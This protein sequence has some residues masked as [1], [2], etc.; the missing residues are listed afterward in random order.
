MRRHSAHVEVSVLA[1]LSAGII[2]GRRAARIHAHMAGCQRCARVSAGLSEVGV[3]LASV[4]PPVMP[5]AVTTRLSAAITEEAIARSGTAVTQVRRLAGTEPFP[6]SGRAAGGRPRNRLASPVAVRACA[7]AA[8][9]CLVAAGG[10][11][12]VQLTSPSRP[13]S[14][15]PR[16][17]NG[18]IAKHG[19]RIGS[20]SF[21]V[22]PPHPGDVT[23]PAQLEPA[24]EV[25]T[26]GTDYQPATL[27]SQ[28]ETELGKIGAGTATGKPAQHQPTGQQAGCV[29]RLVPGVRPA[30]VDA[31]RY[32]GRPATVIALASEGGQLSQAWVVGP[33]CA[34]GE[35]DILTRVR[36][37][38]GG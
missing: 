15:L 9:V 11:T 37:P 8:A 6:R 7:A 21:Q 32:Q 35:N 5:T 22:G 24:F 28:V 31:A 36:L 27:R 13:G 19:L 29:H 12:I 26:S 3:L 38:A 18:G 1:E 4:P 23:P 14:A 33:A 10:Y 34:A 16:G 2:D 25:V 17:A 20:G 30:L